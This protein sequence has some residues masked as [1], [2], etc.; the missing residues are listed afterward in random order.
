MRSNPHSDPLFV[1]EGRS[2]AIELYV[3]RVSIHRQTGRIGRIAGA[4]PEGRSLRI[5]DLTAVV[6]RRC[7]GKAPGSLRLTARGLSTLLTFTPQQEPDFA[8]ATA[9]IEALIRQAQTDGP[10]EP[11]R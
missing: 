3:D 7:A 4:P 1:F 9:F 8:E 10:G 11:T 2:V 5:A 6:F